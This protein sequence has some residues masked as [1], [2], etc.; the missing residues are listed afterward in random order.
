MLVSIPSTI[1]YVHTK[2]N[3]KKVKI[4]AAVKHGIF[5]RPFVDRDLHIFGMVWY[6]VWFCSMV[7]NQTMMVESSL[8]HF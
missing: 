8:D 2:V 7:D 6:L 4:T 5:D 1:L 3:I